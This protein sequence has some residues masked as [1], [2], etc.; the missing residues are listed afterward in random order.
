MN[1]HVRLEVA[2]GG[3]GAAADA[4]LEGPLA[5]VRADV[6]FE[7]LVAGELLGAVRALVHALAGAAPLADCSS[8]SSG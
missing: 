3:E 4:A 5:G 1:A 7:V 2:L 8:E 6:V